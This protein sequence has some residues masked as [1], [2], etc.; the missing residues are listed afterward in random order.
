MYKHILFNND[1]SLLNINI[2]SVSTITG[3][4]KSGII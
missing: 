3:A 4:K 2:M 1:N